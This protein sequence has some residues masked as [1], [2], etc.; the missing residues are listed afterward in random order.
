MR[1][2]LPLARESTGIR[3]MGSKSRKQNAHSPNTTGSDIRST[4][5]K[6][7]L[8]R[9]TYC[10]PCPPDRIFEVR[11]IIRRLSIRIP[12]LPCVVEALCG[13]N[14]RGRPINCK[15]RGYDTFLVIIKLDPMATVPDTA[16]ARPIYLS[17]TMKN[18]VGDEEKGLCGKRGQDLSDGRRRLVR[19]TVTNYLQQKKA[20]VSYNGDI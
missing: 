16:R 18:D 9:L 4:D 13:G 19:I 11:A 2:S 8:R 1:Q 10:H 17:S 5:A 14:E 15:M 7:V 3:D 12:P 20:V 6:R